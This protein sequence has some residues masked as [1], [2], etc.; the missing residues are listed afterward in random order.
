MKKNMIDLLVKLG[1]MLFKYLGTLQCKCC[2]SK[3]QN[4]ENQEINVDMGEEHE[5]PVPPL[6]SSV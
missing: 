6:V 5:K 1:T 4:T 3:C 2:N